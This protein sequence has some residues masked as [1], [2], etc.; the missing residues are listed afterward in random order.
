[1]EDLFYLNV[2]RFAHAVYKNSVDPKTLKEILPYSESHSFIYVLKLQNGGFYVGYSESIKQRLTRHFKGKGCNLTRKAP[3]IEVYKLYRVLNKVMFGFATH[4]II[5]HSL[6]IQL[7]RIYGY[8]KVRG[9][10]LGSSWNSKH[11]A[12]CNMEYLNKI[13]LMMHNSSY[14]KLIES[15]EFIP[16]EGL[17][18][19]KSQMRPI[20]KQECEMFNPIDKPL[21]FS[22]NTKISYRPKIGKYFGFAE[23][24]Y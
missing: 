20:M 22:N 24:H 3:P 16:T 13:A 6:A 11:P 18:I 10:K 17:K 5:E 9:A 2:Q 21:K 1:M 7:A 4:E 12:K 8:E 23:G 19:H 15:L 14:Q